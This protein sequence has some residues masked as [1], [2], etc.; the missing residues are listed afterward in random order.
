M[1]VLIGP[2]QVVVVLL[3]AGGALKAV[4]PDDTA[5]ALRAFGVPVPMW[6]VRAAGVGEAGIASWALLSGNRV[7][8]ALVGISYAGFAAFVW[9]AERRSLPIA[10]CGCFGRVDTP[11]SAVH[12]G[13]NLVG[14]AVAFGVALVGGASYT[15]VVAGQPLAGVPYTAM[16]LLGA[17]LAFVALTV[18]PRVLGAT[19][20]SRGRA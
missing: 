2:F 9:S 17:W 13:V 1:T 19:A 15:D 11:P 16:V 10:S 5:G 12:L 7:A 4:R 14:S 20:D 6:G 18:L 8:A 3:L